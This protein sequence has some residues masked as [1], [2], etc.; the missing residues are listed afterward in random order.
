MTALPAYQ[1]QRLRGLFICYDAGHP[2]THRVLHQLLEKHQGA[3]QRFLST[4][5]HL[6]VDEFQ[7]N[8][9]LQSQLLELMVDAS[10]PKLT[11]VGDDDQCI[12]QFRGAEP[13]NFRRLRGVFSSLVDRTLV[14]NYRSSANILTVAAVFL[15]EC[16]RREDKTLLATRNTG[17][18]V[19]LWKVR[20]GVQQA[21][22]I[23]T[24]VRRR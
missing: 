4:F 16:V 10:A 18:P 22:E 24:E 9:E 11:V 23:A 13:G 5:A 19:E 12:Y 8:S 15:K 2:L 20:D 6:I 14:D 21:K 7:D 1:R 3:R 17:E